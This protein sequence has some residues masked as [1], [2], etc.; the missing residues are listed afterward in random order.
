MDAVVTCVTR[1]APVTPHLVCA[2]LA[3]QVPAVQHI[4]VA[5]AGCIQRVGRIPQGEAG[6]RGAGGGRLAQRDCLPGGGNALG[7]WGGGAMEE[8]D[9]WW[10]ASLGVRRH[11]CNKSALWIQD[12]TCHLAWVNMMTDWAGG[13]H[14]G[15]HG[16]KYQWLVTS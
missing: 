9:V 5:A 1:V 6:G 4:R 12:Y 14:S 16:C 3:Q 2:L 13:G 15:C 7:T 11:V 10:V 8:E